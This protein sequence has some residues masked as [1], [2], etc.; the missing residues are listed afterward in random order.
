MLFSSQIHNKIRRL[1][2][3]PMARPKIFRILYPL[4]FHRLRRAT[5]K[6]VRVFL[7]PCHATS[8]VYAFS[9]QR[10]RCHAVPAGDLVQRS[11][12]ARSAKTLPPATMSI[13]MTRLTT[14]LGFCT[15]TLAS[16]HHQLRSQHLT[17]RAADGRGD[18]VGR[19]VRFR[20]LPRRAN[21]R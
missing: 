1:Q 20:Q 2:A 17:T 9:L 4:C 7:L 13:P 6:K 16:N 3:I 12:F 8:C 14:A 19:L 21:A 5:F 11:A 10:S 18:H 15:I